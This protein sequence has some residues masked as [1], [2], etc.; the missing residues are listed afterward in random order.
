MEKLCK[1][2]LLSHLVVHISVRSRIDYKT[3]SLRPRK[4]LEE[5]WTQIFL[6]SNVVVLGL[7]R[8]ITVQQKIPITSHRK[9]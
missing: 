6:D 3:Y 4:Q 5:P 7:I 9:I 2:L 1:L 8:P